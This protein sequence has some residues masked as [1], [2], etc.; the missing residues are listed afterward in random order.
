MQPCDFIIAVWGESHLRLLSEAAVPTL[1]APGNLPGF[2]S[3][4]PARFIVYTTHEGERFLALQPWTQ[5]IARLMPFEVRVFMKSDPATPLDHYRMWR[6]ATVDARA[7]GHYVFFLVPDVVWADGSLLHVAGLLDQGKRAMYTVQPRIVQE[8]ALPELLARTSKSG[9]GTITVSTLEMK[10]FA[11]RHMHPY[12]ASSLV[13]GRHVPRQL[14][15]LTWYDPGNGFEVR[16]LGLHPR[17]FDPACF[18]LEQA[19][20][21]FRGAPDPSDL[22]FITDSDR[23]ASFSLTPFRAY[24]GYHFYPNTP[25]VLDTARWWLDWRY[26]PTQLVFSQRFLF[27][28]EKPNALAGT[29]GPSARYARELL[30]SDELIEVAL[31]LRDQGL[32]RAAE[33]LAY[34]LEAGRLRRAYRAGQALR[35]MA[36]VD[37]AL[38]RPGSREEAA[39]LADPARLTR[40]MALH[41][42]PLAQGVA[43]IEGSPP[44]AGQPF[45]VRGHEVTPVSRALT[46]PASGR[47]R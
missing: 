27:N 11:A 42:R 30:A 20:F 38:P 12:P 34:A 4:R 6:A 15:Q 26:P 28:S 46:L 9:D 16:P 10:R 43:A 41:I 14:E 3:R 44:P 24:F 17:G 23:A 29:P 22:A 40:L 37:E 39:L 45:T 8:T 35:I 32:R 21:D 18:E 13:M 47:G 7:R 36:P 2:A 31:A 1:L 33:Y 19:V 25:G 5:S